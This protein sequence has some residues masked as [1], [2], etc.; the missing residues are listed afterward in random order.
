[1]GDVE[2]ML[3]K[4]GEIYIIRNIVIGDDTKHSIETTMWNDVASNE[5]L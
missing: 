3:T 2:D 5:D 4:S 1:M